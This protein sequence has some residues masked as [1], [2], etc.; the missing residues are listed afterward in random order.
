MI[1][2]N[3]YITETKEL[4]KK[5]FTKTTNNNKERKEE[6]IKYLKNK[7]YSDY[8][9]TL[10]KM[11]KDEKTKAL[12]FDGFGGEL[13]DLKL[14]FN[15]NANIKVTALTPTQNEIDITK[16]INFAMAYPESNIPNYFSKNVKVAGMPIIT[17]KKEFVI[18]GHHRWSQVFAYNPN[19]IMEAIDYSSDEINSQQ[20]LKATQ[21]AIAAVIAQNDNL[22][23]IPQEKVNGKNVYDFDEQGIKE[24]ISDV[25][26]GKEVA[27]IDKGEKIYVED[28]GEKF[29]K[30]LSKYVD[31][32]K[33]VETAAEYI[34]GNFMK[35][36]VNHSP[37]QGAP[38]RG[39]MPQTDKG[40]PD[41]N[42]KN[43]G[44]D[45]NGSALNKLA[46]NEI[47]KG[48]VE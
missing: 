34:A 43:S 16:S 35:L 9:E 19:A 37:I 7:N 28:K 3:N 39:D 44:P 6:L 1:H 26:S 31:S 10:N 24:Y 18:D 17:F 12:I 45:K 33:D 15:P 23:E 27:I 13:G 20:M 21:G 5:S 36:K 25:L 29:V 47:V 46:K 11:L 4:V 32:V 30:T 40:A 41:G 48:A 42:K 38:N 22:D 14:D 8:I 2:L